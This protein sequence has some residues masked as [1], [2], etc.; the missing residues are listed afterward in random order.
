MTIT[1]CHFSIFCE[2]AVRICICCFEPVF[3]WR[4]RRK[5]KEERDGFEQKKLY[6]YIS[7]DRDD[8]FF[9]RGVGAG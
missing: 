6:I 3:G 8:C 5:K 2:P 9:G 4:R 1:K 7:A